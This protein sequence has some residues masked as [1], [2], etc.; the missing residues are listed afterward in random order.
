MAADDTECVDCDVCGE[1][2]DCEEC[3]CF[4]GPRGVA[5]TVFI[6]DELGGAD[7]D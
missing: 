1:C 4:H 5:I 3:R 6:V 7:C 2:I